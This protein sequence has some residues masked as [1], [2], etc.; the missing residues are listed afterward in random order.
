M[1]ERS[2]DLHVPGAVQQG[3]SPDKDH[4]AKGPDISQSHDSGCYTDSLD[5]PSADDLGKTSKE[6]T[7]NGV[8]AELCVSGRGKER[9]GQVEP[10]VCSGQDVQPTE[11]CD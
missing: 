7:E 4:Q 8:G 2:Q 11:V 5:Q 6:E 3:T 9:E 1:A 10:A